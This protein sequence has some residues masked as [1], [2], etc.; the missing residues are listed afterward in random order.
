MTRFAHLLAAALGLRLARTEPAY[1]RLAHAIALL[2]ALDLTRGGARLLR[3]DVSARL[4]AYVARL[5]VPPYE[6]I[7]RWSWAV[8]QV[9]TVSWYAVLAGAVW[10]GLEKGKAPELPLESLAPACSPLDGGT[11]LDRRN[12]GLVST[13]RP[14]RLSRNIP[15]DARQSP[16]ILSALACCATV[17]ALFLAYPAVRGRPVELALVAVFLLALAVQ[18]VAVTRYTLRWQRPDAV[19]GVALILAIGSVADLVM[20]M[21]GH[22][23]RDWSAAGPT[24]V[25]I[26]CAVGGVEAWCLA[27]G[28]R[29]R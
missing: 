9:A 7:A 10:R 26:W 16:P 18:L 19:K 27:A 15:S 2:L 22:P 17:P 23:T 12:G 8:E 21:Q 3:G 13:A 6:G 11:H 29:W 25:L 24:G 5:P 20:W 28:R 14:Q 1:R 4:T